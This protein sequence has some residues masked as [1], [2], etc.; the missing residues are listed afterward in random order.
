M[1]WSIE[2]VKYQESSGDWQVVISDGNT[3]ES[4]RCPLAESQDPTG[5]VSQIIEKRSQE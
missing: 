2:S 3:K 4:I 5:I 1:S